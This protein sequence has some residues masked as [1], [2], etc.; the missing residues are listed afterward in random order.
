MEKLEGKENKH[1][2]GE[3]LELQVQ[4]TP[5]CRPTKRSLYNLLVTSMTR[6]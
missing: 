1:G 5:T 2:D 4:T 6:W 3:E